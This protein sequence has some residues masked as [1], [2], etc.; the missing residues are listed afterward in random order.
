MPWVQALDNAVADHVIGGGTYTKVAT[1]FVGLSTTTPTKV[2]G[3][4]TEP[5]G[6]GYARVSVTNNATNWPNTSGSGL[7]SNGTVITFPV[8]T[9]AGWGTVTHVVVYDASTAGT[10][11]MYGLLT[12]PKLISSGDTASFAI[13][14]I[15]LQMGPAS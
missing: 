2:G 14:A 9:G 13:G 1:T 6:N 12:T 4:V 11:M 7:K 3:N 5:V 8:A 15:D 10:F